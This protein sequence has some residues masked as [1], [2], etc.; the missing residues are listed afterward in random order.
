MPVDIEHILE[1][2]KLLHDADR[3]AALLDVYAY[4]RAKYGPMFDTA[5]EFIKFLE[6]LNM[7]LQSELKDD[8]TIPAPEGGRYQQHSSVNID[9]G[10]ETETDSQAL[11]P[12]PSD[13]GSI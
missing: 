12:L 5:D 6:E 13:S 10:S 3:P 4:F 7:P 1:L 2:A 8:R 11:T 9:S